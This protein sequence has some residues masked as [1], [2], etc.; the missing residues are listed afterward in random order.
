VIAHRANVSACINR[1]VACVQTCGETRETCNAPA[2]AALDGVLAS[3]TAARNAAVAA[4]QA[5][6]P[7]GGAGLEA[8]I[9]MALASTVTC[10]DEAIQESLP[11]FAACTETY[12]GCLYAC[13]RAT[14][15]GETS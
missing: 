12:V 7:T 8:C 5:A 1:D 10:R 6:N 15:P 9:D 4:C 2:R 3:C 13:P 11:S 14:P